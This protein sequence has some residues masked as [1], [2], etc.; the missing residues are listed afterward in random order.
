MIYVNLKNG[1]TTILYDVQAGHHTRQFSGQKPERE[2]TPYKTL[3]CGKKKK[4]PGR[5]KRLWH[6]S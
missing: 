6:L 1:K 3:A 4:N 2:W 5:H